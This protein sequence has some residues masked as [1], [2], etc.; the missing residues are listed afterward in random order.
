MMKKFL[1]V[2]VCLLTLGSGTL[3][4]QVITEADV[5]QDVFVS[6][7]YK[8]PD[9]VVST[10]ERA[11]SNYIARF[12]LNDQVGTATFAADGKWIASAFNVAEKELPSPVSSYI[13]EHY[14][15][16]IVKE[17]NL[18]KLNDGQ[19][20]YFIALK[21]QSAKEM[22]ELRFALDGKL[23]SNTDPKA[24][25]AP[26]VREKNP[27]KE[28][29]VTV[30]KPQEV[31]PKPVDEGEPVKLEKVPA[32]AK[33][34]FTSKNKKVT[35]AAW[36]LKDRA[37]IVR[38]TVT[39][40]KAYGLYSE[41][42]NWK[43]TH[44]DTDPLSLSP[45]TQDYLKSNFRRLKV[46]R[47]DFVQQAPKYKYMDVYL[48]EKSSKLTNPPIHKVTFDGNGKFMSYEKPDVD[49]AGVSNGD[50]DDKAFLAEV[51]AS[52]QVVETGTGIN[53]VISPR[54]LPTDA[55]NYIAKNHKD[56]SIKTCRY[57]F[58]DDLNANVYYV[59]VKKE[60]DR[61]E[62][63]LYFDLMGRMVKKIDPT[64]QN[65][66][67]DL[68][69]T[70]PGKQAEN[71]PD[72]SIEDMILA[73]AEEVDPGDLPSGITNFVKKNYPD[74]RIGQALYTTH[75]DFGNVYCVEVKKPGDKS[76][77]ELWF[78]LNGKLVKTNKKE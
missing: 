36:F 75:D 44:I 47:A 28:N 39:G 50:E 7:K 68:Q 67:K 38:Y 1:F 33:T 45:I 18:Q 72:A 37:Y 71:A 56:M 41:E 8:Y 11:E 73:G 55:V 52:N 54:E 21:G 34:H 51:D 69:E 24:S 78:D 3:Q 61:R 13:K 59:T 10:W 66:Q 29:Q 25:K 49:E 63:E 65:V 17:C 26:E 62:I 42:G 30:D 14:A 20:L 35:D 77:V 23:L 46:L 12:K 15:Y 4:A 19:D 31:V 43:E 70:E 60:G 58:D 2:L 16:N 22:I 64:E 32:L 9:A 76:N 27:V 6:M 57:L 53:D 40:R 5:P 48:V 74:Y